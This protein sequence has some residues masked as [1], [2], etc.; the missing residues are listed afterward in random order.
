VIFVVGVVGW[1]MILTAFVVLSAALRGTKVKNTCSGSERAVPSRLEEQR[2]A[3]CK[4]RDKQS[5]LTCRR[6]AAWEFDDK[7]PSDAI[8]EETLRDSRA[9]AEPA[10]EIP[11]VSDQDLPFEV[12]GLVDCTP[13]IMNNGRAWDVLHKG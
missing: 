10:I 4:S 3:I 5:G 13:P 7:N 9:K 6:R 11:P 8:F 12:K 1:V 2:S